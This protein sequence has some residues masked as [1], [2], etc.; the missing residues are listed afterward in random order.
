[1]KVILLEAVPGLGNPGDVKEVS[2]GFGRNYLLPK[3]LAVF[4]TPQELKRVEVIRRTSERRSLRTR[5]E[6]QTLVQQ[7]EGSTITMRAKAGAK[8]RLYGSITN[9]H[10]AEELSKIY[11]CEIDKRKVELQEPIRQL[12]EYQVTVR[13]LQ[14]LLPKVKVIVEGEKGEKAE[15]LVKAESAGA[16]EQSGVVALPESESGGTEV[17]EQAAGEKPEE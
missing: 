16:E 3:K 13:L 12:G 14:D 8:G 5:E 9:A 6:M 10:V 17:K 7:L 15:A 4:A 2:D 1:M 11:N